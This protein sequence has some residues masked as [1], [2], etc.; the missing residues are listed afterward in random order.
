MDEILWLPTLELTLPLIISMDLPSWVL[1]VANV[2]LPAAVISIPIL[3]LRWA[4]HSPVSWHEVIAFIIP[5]FLWGLVCLNSNHQLAMLGIAFYFG[6]FLPVVWLSE[7]KPFGLE[8]YERYAS[9]TLLGVAMA[10][11][12][13]LCVFFLGSQELGPAI[14]LRQYI[15]DPAIIVW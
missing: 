2:L 8:R 5:I 12:P 7:F 15:A 1:V 6:L 4:H 13:I 11:G 10:M 14:S 3:L 9:V